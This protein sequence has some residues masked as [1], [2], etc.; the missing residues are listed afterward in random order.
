MINSNLTNLSME[1]QTDFEILTEECMKFWFNDQGHIRSPFPSHIHA[2]LRDL[3]KKAFQ[4][5]VDQNA[6]ETDL[7]NENNALKFEEILFELAFT[8]VKTDDEKISLRY[9]FLPRIHDPLEIKKLIE[10]KETVET[11]P[12]IDRK[13]IEEE[14]ASFLEVSLLNKENQIWKT[15]FPLPD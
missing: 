4:L 11:H 15:R 5:W 8:L 7:D 12:I 14:D 3:A 9:P 1:N 10:G 2:P 6:A 13:I